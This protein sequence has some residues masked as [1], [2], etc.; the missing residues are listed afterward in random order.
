MKNWVCLLITVAA[1]YGADARLTS[2]RIEPSGR[3]LRGAEAHQ[4]LLAIGRFDDGSELDLTDAAYWTSSNPKLGEVNGHAQLQAIGNGAIVVTVAAQG[5]RAQARFEAKEIDDTRPFEFGQDIDGIFTRKGC[6]SPSCHGGVKGRGGLKL[7][8]GALHPK[9]D[10]EWIVKGGAYQVLTAEVKGPRTPRIDLREPEKSLLLLKPTAAVA[11]GGGRRFTKDADEYLKILKWIRD[12]APYGAENTTDNRVARL[13]VFPP[14]VT[15]QAGGKQRLLVTAHFVDGRAEDFTDHALFV[16][17][18]KDIA[19]VDESGQV[20]AGKLGETAILVRAAGQ[21]GSATVGVVGAPVTHYAAV[22]PVNFIDEHVF[23]KLRRFRIEPSDRSSDSEFLRRICLDLAG[24]L[25]PPDRAKEFLASKD[26]RK[27]EKLIDVL[28]SS[29]EFVD[30]LTFHFDDLFRVALFPNGIRPKWSEMYGEWVRSSIAV[31][32]PYDVMAKERL[33]AEGYDGPTRHYL[34]YD[35][36]GP[37]NDTMAEEVRVFFGRR[38]DCAQCH[39]H[40]YESWSQDQFWGMAAFFGRQFKMGDT[41]NEYVIFE[42]PLNEEM[43]NGDVNGSLTMYHPRTKAELKPTL[44]DGTVVNAGPRQNQR[45]ILADWMVKQ[46]YFAEAAVNRI[47]S[48]YFGRGIVEPVDDFRSTNPPTHPELLRRLAEDF[49]THN[50]DL[51]RLIREIVTSATYQTSGVPK[52][53]NESDRTNYSHALPRALDAEVLLDAIC[54]V[55]GVPETFTMGGSEDS[56]NPGRAPLGTR[57]INLREPDLYYSRFLDVYGRPNR[58]TLPERS[59]KANLGEALDML[60]GPV[61]NEKLSAATGRL[62]RLRKAGKSDDEV[63]QEFY[64]AAF[65]RLPDTAEVSAVRSL[66]EKQGNG[67]AGLQDFVWALLCSREFAEN[68]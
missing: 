16:S 1:L 2:L 34:P 57:A 25:P 29:P 55:T 32:K 52:V 42:H 60:A 49:R 27:R 65:S 28:M 37:P 10:Y 58:L 59:G 50:Y 68:H 17:N 30:Y 7:S 4:Q 33:G 3:V 44:L 22:K 53:N 12:G 47:W 48:W 5:Q 14:V 18:E 21:V 6:N 23:D 56:K 35:V 61:Y 15:L 11:H 36:I 63:M 38:L 54:D 43:G 20:Q 31:N 40:P 41:G 26:P 8:A 46:P 51:R 24:T 45:K 9:D 66:I 39:N 62:E 19:S 64:L 67:E 13:E